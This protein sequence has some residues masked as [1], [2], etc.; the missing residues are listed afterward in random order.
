MY[1]YS[2][3]YHDDDDHHHDPT[4]EI[5][6]STGPNDPKPVPIDCKYAIY[7]TYKNLLEVKSALLLY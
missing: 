4:E 5:S 3:G 1:H 6:G 2:D 7:L